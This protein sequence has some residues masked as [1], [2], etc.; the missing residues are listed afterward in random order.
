V[1]LEALRT[2]RGNL[3]IKDLAASTAIRSDDI[4]STLQSLNLIRFWKG[5]HVISVSAKIVDEH[6]RANCR[7]SLRCDPSLL[8]WRPPEAESG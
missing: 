6:L 3:S 1:L 7:Q 4:I 2:Q 8:T 5:Q